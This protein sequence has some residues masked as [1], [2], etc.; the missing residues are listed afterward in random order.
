[1][2]ETVPCRN[3]LFQKFRNRL[4]Y[5]LPRLADC[6]YRIHWL[7]L[8]KRISTPPQRVY[9]IWHWTIWWW[10]SNEKEPIFIK[11]HEGQE[12]RV[13][14]NIFKLAQTSPLSKHFYLYVRREKFVQESDS[15]LTDRP[16]AWALPTRRID[17]D[18]N[19]TDSP[20]LGWSLAMVTLSFHSSSYMASQKIRTPPSRPA[21]DSAILDRVVLLLEK[22]YV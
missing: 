15:E 10:G 14:R 13:C 6:S 8:C 21:S 2:R 17:I 5:Y 1:M 20:Y 22:P 4:L 19:R 16:L 18:D 9:W 7:H 3:S 11:S 12:K